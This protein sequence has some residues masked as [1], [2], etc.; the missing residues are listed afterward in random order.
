MARGEFKTAMELRPKKSSD[1]TNINEVKKHLITVFIESRREKQLGVITDFS[2]QRF[3]FG[4][5]F[6]RLRG[7][8]LGGKGRG[9]AFMRSL[10]TKYDLEKKYKNVKITVPNTIVIG[11]LEFDRFIQENN[12]LQ[13]LE[14]KDV[15]DSH[16]AEEFLKSRINDELKDNLATILT[17]FKC[18]IAVRSSSLLEDSLSHPFAGIFSTYMLPNN[19]KNQTIRLRQL[20]EAI[21]L[22]YASV[23]FKEPRVY[24][25]STSAKIEEEKM[26]VI[27]QEL[28][29]KEYQGHYYPTFSGVAQSYNFYPVSHQKYEDGIV[30]IA[31]GLGKTVVGGGKVLRF[32]PRYPSILPDFSTPE[33]ILKNSQKELYVLD[34]SKKDFHLSERDDSTLEKISVENIKGDHL[35]EPITSTFDRNDGMIRDSWSEQG[36]HLITFAGVLKYDVFPLAS[37]IQDIL[38]IGQRGMGCPVEIEFAVQLSK[39]SDI[40]HIFSILQLRPLV[41]SH[42]HCEVV[43]DDNIN[44]K[45][46]FLHSETALGNGIIKS[47]KDIIYVQPERFDNSLTIQIADEIGKIN[48]TLASGSIPYILIGPGR[49]GSQDRFL[50]IPV[51]WSQISKVRV[52]VETSLEDFKIEPSQGTHFFH[53]ITSRGIGYINV[54][55]KSKD[56]FIDW[57]WLEKQKSHHE[58]RYVKHIKLSQPLIIKLDGRC[59]HAII[60][61]PESR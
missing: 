38:N 34:I 1:F 31:V 32:S 21:K 20:C 60:M 12:L 29:G 18:P 52:M 2:N 3:E 44:R 17:H 8:S 43:W 6:T 61:K 46:V 22:V 15:S 4:N 42:E 49:W 13:F 39:E 56:S 23:F 16:I 36:P 7:D 40:P 54:P 58:G 51:N 27:I 50:G 57:S 47:V 28:V 26:A 5:S 45:D 41:P 19:H 11:T 55:Y 53:N 37:I 9:I 48:K 35:I 24:I 10:L 33:E 30:N 59:N 14:D 25:E